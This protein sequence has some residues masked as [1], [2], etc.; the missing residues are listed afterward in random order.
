M[1]Q[2]TLKGGLTARQMLLVV[3]L[4]LLVVLLMVVLFSQPTQIGS[5]TLAIK[6]GGGDFGGGG[7][8]GSY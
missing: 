7:A 1:T 6:F 4:L 3:A 8:G 2:L 5:H